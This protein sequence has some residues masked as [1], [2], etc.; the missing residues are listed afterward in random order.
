MY[1]F[2]TLY[3]NPKHW[4]S[5]NS[6]ITATYALGDMTA[7]LLYIHQGLSLDNKYLKGLIF[8]KRIFSQHPHLKEDFYSL[9]PHL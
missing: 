6:I 9:F 5:I 2:Q 3:R 7:C 8:K 4:L 1:L